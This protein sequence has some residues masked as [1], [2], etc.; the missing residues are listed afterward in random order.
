[1]R[2]EI[3]RYAVDGMIAAPRSEQAVLAHD[4]VQK[5]PYTFLSGNITDLPG[6]NTS[7]YIHDISITP[8]FAC[9]DRFISSSYTVTHATF[10]TLQDASYCMLRTIIACCYARFSGEAILSVEDVRNV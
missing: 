4:R 6:M 10:V 3:M 5:D 1:M 8:E 2:G 7:L 9:R